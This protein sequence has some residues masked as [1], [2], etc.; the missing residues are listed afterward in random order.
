VIWRTSATLGTDPVVAWV[1][2][3][4]AVRTVVVE[5]ANCR[6]VAVDTIG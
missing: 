2:G 3:H 4:G 6:L 1:F 5:D